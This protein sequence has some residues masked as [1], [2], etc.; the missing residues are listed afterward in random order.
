MPLSI[1]HN[2]K[3]CEGEIGGLKAASSVPESR[4]L[5]L[6]QKGLSYRSAKKKLRPH[7]TSCAG[8][9]A[10]PK[11]VKGIRASMLDVTDAEEVPLGGH[12]E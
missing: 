8:S 7:Y 11:D 12:T 9:L 5:G 10:A 4:V 3:T 2:A 6:D 1:W